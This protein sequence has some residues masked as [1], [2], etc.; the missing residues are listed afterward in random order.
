MNKEILSSKRIIL[1]GDERYIRDFMYVF[2]D[3]QP[4][5]FVNDIADGFALSWER[6]KEERIEDLL[7][8]V[9]KYEAVQAT[10]NLERIGLKKGETYISAEICFEWLDFPIKEISNFRNVY[11][12]GTGNDGHDFFKYLAEHSEIQITGTIDSNIKRIGHTF[13]GKPIYSP[14]DILRTNKPFIIIATKKYYMEIRKELEKSGLKNKE[15]FISYTGINQYASEMMKRTIFDF[16]KTDFLC[17]K[18]FRAYELKRE[19]RTLICGGMFETYD[20]VEPMYYADFIDIWNSNVLKVVRLSCVNGTYTF[21]NQ[22]V[23]NHI[24]E[25]C[26]SSIDPEDYQYERE[27][28]KEQLKY[29]KNKKKYPRNTVFAADNYNKRELKYPATVQMGFDDTCNFQ[30]PSC[31]KEIYCADS[32]KISE[33][34]NFKKRVYEEILDNVLRIKVAGTGEAFASSVY[35]EMIFD[36]AL[37]KRLDGIGIISN[38][39]LF[40]PAAFKKISNIWKSINIFISMDGATKNTAEK[41]RKGVKFEKW[42]QNMEYLGEMKKQGKISKFAFNFVVQKDNYLEMPAFVEMCLGFQ[43]DKI[44][45]SMVT[46]WGNWTKEEFNE[47][48]MFD[49]NGEMKPELAEVLQNDIFSRPEVFLFKWIDW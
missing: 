15:D 25:K 18:P 42:K 2:D 21:C 46:N 11:V 33:L 26:V 49:E 29:L 23:C 13:Y 28:T 35:R 20:K 41:L 4:I 8:I 14:E 34:N 9:C 31:R 22:I 27:K 5:Y 36:Q 1:Y 47:I 19:G 30:C 16:P 39:S 24:R 45:F 48:S 38:G 6:I 3:I 10:L 44:K 40:D 7:V 12:W 17:E 32:E 43:A 37:A